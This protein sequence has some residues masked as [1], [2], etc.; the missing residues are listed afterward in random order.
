MAKNKY[1]IDSY[2]GS[3]LVASVCFAALISLF[4]VGHDIK[5]DV[6]LSLTPMILAGTVLALIFSWVLKNFEGEDLLQLNDKAFGKI[7]GKIVNWILLLLFLGLT[8]Y[9]ILTPI[10]MF[11]SLD[12]WG[13]PLLVYI[14]IVMIIVY[15]CT[16]LGLE[17]IARMSAIFVVIIIFAVIFD[18]LVLIPSMHL[19]RIMPIAEYGWK[20]VGITGGK[21]FILQYAMLP[22]ALLF[23]PNLRN[24]ADAPRTLRI[25]LMI[26]GVYFVVAVLRGSLIFG[27]LVQNEIFPTL[28]AMRRVQL[29]SDISR[30]E[31]GGLLALLAN[32]FIFICIALYS[33]SKLS[34]CD[35][36]PKKQKKGL[37]LFA[38]II[39]VGVYTLSHFISGA[40]DQL[41]IRYVLIAG[42]LVLAIFLL[43]VILL[44]LRLNLQKKQV[45]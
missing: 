38:V 37:A 5:H 30:V 23:L 18:T 12:M 8:I 45:K 25:G 1:M 14:I 4:L 36:D 28:Q 43:M 7:G 9:H 20:G 34:G 32:K 11:S 24:S 41:A 44:A 21:F 17:V 35:Q 3:S 42:I 10:Y 15:Y 39:A 40:N 29:G 16:S 13:T 19:D 27:D 31:L 2:Q 22:A 6:W 33:I 26:A